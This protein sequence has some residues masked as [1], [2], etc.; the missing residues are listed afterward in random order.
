MAFLLFNL[1][2][3]FFPTPWDQDAW[4]TLFLGHERLLII[5]NVSE[6]VVGF[7]LFD[8]SVADS[9]AHLLKIMIHPDFRKRGLSRKL[10]DS[11]ILNLES[12]GCHEFFL[13]VEEGNCAAQS[14]YR[15]AGFEVIH[16][17]KDFYGANR[18]ALI[19]TRT[20][21]SHS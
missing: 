11:A 20:N 2:K 6:E 1:D 4:E 13:E 10:L 15:S 5:L 16:R 12:A 7:C 18:A 8:K 14:L 19:M 9:F 17:K 21:K 3:D